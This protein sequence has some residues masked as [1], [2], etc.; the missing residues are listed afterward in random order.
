M[1]QKHGNNNSA[2]STKLGNRKKRNTASSNNSVSSKKSTSN[3][4]SKQ[5]KKAPERAIDPAKYLSDSQRI[6]FTLRN[7]YNSLYSNLISNLYV[8]DSSAILVAISGGVDSVTLLDSMAVLSEKYNYKLQ[9]I[10][11][12]H[13][14]RGNESNN[15]E[16]FV[17]ALCMEYG[18]ECHTGRGDVSEFAKRNSLSVEEAARI[19]R[20]KYFE[21]VA[22]NTKPNFLVTAHTANDS[23]ETFMINLFRGTGL[24]GLC[25]IPARRKFVKSSQLIRPL[26]IFKKAELIKIAKKRGL[27]WREDST[28]KQSTFLRNKIRNELIP[29]IEKE[30]SVSVVELL[31]RVS[32][33]IHGAD[34]FIHEFVKNTMKNL[35][36]DR[37]FERFAIRIPYFQTFDDFIKGEIIQYSISKYLKSG[38]ASLEI[39]EKILE[40]LP[41]SSG[42]MCE[43]NDKIRVI[44]DRNEL[45]FT[46]KA[47]I[48]IVDEIISREGEFE[49][50]SQ[51]IILETVERK[52]VNFSSNPE[53]EYFDMEFMPK[54]L[55]IR[56]WREGDFFTPLGMDGR[57]KLSDYFI[58]SKVSIPDKE[59]ALVLTDKLDVIWICGMRM[60]DKYKVTD[61]SRK[62]LKA[63][64]IDNKN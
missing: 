10:H 36:V 11:Y 54:L 1:P 46:L 4:I 37:T 50:G 38:P 32:R 12:N 41:K 39:I 31:N 23:A 55:Q 33:H 64:F 45:I 60:S 29:L 17:K 21:K 52:D 34:K 58:N 9:A 18:V 14:L 5:K 22:Q 27:K 2:T 42:T 26:L 40:L 47:E 35:I 8:D 49:Y 7:F 51:K 56:N 48:K 13:G 3:R 62:I 30:Y 6:D 16:E 63:T 57:V 15:D 53:I 61:S 43:I 44:R 20:Y 25:G 24:T 28:N 19:L 59:K